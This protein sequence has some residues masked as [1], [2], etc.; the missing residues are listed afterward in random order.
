[1]ENVKIKQYADWLLFLGI[2][3]F[4]FGLIT[5]LF[6]PIMSN[7]RMGL[8]AHLEGVM[9]GMFLVIIGLLW[10][11]LVLTAKWLTISF[12]LLVYGSFANFIA[13]TIA[14]VTGAGKMMPIALGK[15]GTPVVEGLIS[16]LLVSLALAMI[17][18]CCIVLTGLYRY[19]KQTSDSN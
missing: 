17:T 19:I 16:F 1:M 11:K 14:A 3:L 2:L 12:W 8:T 10:G 6:I 13:V 15:E 5:G 7:P 9:N 4:L 18:V